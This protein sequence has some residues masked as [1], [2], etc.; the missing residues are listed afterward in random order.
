M[1]AVDDKIITFKPLSTSESLSDILRM[2]DA[3]I[4]VSDLDNQTT[5]VLEE[6]ADN[7]AK[8][9]GLKVENVTEDEVTFIPL[10]NRRIIL[11][12]A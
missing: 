2:I 12:V 8:F 7:I 3:S 6:W 4:K 1:M 10:N 5:E 11:D 9:V